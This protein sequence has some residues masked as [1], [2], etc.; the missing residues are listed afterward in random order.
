MKLQSYIINE[1]FRATGNFLILSLSK[2]A[3]N[4]Q[5]WPG[6]W[7]LS[8]PSHSGHVSADLDGT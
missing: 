8:V 2:C 5:M 3:S 1:Y 7:M 6:L 4:D